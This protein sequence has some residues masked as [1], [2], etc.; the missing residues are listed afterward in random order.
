MC[1]MQ[2]LNELAALFCGIIVIV[3]AAI[4]ICVMLRFINA[5]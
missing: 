1:W 4:V 3:L 2:R 5:G